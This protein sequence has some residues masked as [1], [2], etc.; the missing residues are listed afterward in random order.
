MLDSGINPSLKD[1]MFRYCSFMNFFLRPACPNIS[2][3]D[4]HID[5][6]T[7]IRNLQKVIPIIQP[8]AVIF[9]SKMAY[10]VAKW[11]KENEA[12]DL[13]LP[14]ISV[15]HPGSAW[16]NRKSSKYVGPDLN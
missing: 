8:D 15:P 6:E 1:N 3:N 16:W 7:A 14:T 2:I 10:N 4:S 9:V 13:G 12:A 11:Y 5:R